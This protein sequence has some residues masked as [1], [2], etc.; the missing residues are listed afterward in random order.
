[1]NK[2]KYRGAKYGFSGKIQVSESKNPR[3]LYI[4]QKEAIKVLTQ[5]SKKDIFK[6]LLVIPTGGGKTF[7]SVYWVLKEIINKNKKVL[8]LAHRH[9]L[10]NQTLETAVKSSYKDVLPNR[11][12]FS[13]RIISGSLAHDNPV[14]IDKDD[15]FIIAS[16]DSLNYNP[17][18]LKT[19]LDNNKDNICLVIDEAHHATAKTYRN[20]IKMVENSCNNNLNIIGLT[21]TPMRTSEKEKGLLGKIFQDG[22]CYSVD[23]KT[24]I[25]NK[26]LS[27]PVIRDLKT[28]FKMKRELNRSELN[29]LTKFKNLPDSVAKDIAIN[30]ERNNFI[31]NNYIEN[32]AEYGK[33]LVFAVNID[34]A[35]ALNAL[36]KSKG[37]KSDFVVSSIKDGSTGAT[38]S[39]EE[40]E[41][42]IE[43]FRNN[44]LDVLINVNI[45]TEG[46]DIPDVQTV[47][48]TRPTTS[49][50]LMN[51]MI[52]RGLRGKKAGG[53]EK[54]YIVSFIDD[55]QYRI[56]WINPKN[57]LSFG[58]FVEDEIN[59][60]R[61][62]SATL[63]PIKMIEEFAKLMDLSI[64]KKMIGGSYL[65]L[66]PIGSYYFNIFDEDEYIDKNCEVLIFDHLIN[67]YEQLIENLE[68]IFRMFEVKDDKVTEE[69][70]TQMYEYVLNEIFAGYDL[71]IGFN[72]EDIKDILRYYE[73]TGE[74]LELIAFEGRED[75]DISKLVDEILDKRFNRIEEAEYIK[76]KWEDKSLGWQIYFN[77]DFLLFNSEID[78]EM[79]NRFIKIPKKE[80][81][82]DSNPIDFKTLSMHQIRKLDVNLWRKL[83][84]EVFN[85]FRD[86][87][88]Y[89]ES[90]SG[91]YK[92]RNK[93]YFQIDHIKPISKG[94]LTE[95][96]NLQLLTRWENGIKGDKLD[97]RF[98]ELESEYKEEALVECY[99]NKDEKKAQ[100]IIKMLL[101]ENEECIT[102]LNVRSRIQFENEKYM[103]AI[104]TANQVLNICEDNIYALYTKAN[105][106]FRQAKYEKAIDISEKII[107][108]NQE[109]SYAYIILGDCFY[110]LRKYN[111]AISYYHKALDIDSNI[112]WSNFRLGWIYSRNRRYNLSNQYYL[113]A[114]Q[115]DN[116]CADSLNNIGCNFL[117]VNDYEEALKYFEMALDI[118]S[119]EPVYKENRK[120]ALRE[121]KN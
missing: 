51:Q 39:N 14:N 50:I 44:K 6:S 3:G 72:E 30:K 94:G 12:E 77:R 90:A 36:F 80:P 97:F 60:K 33:C 95:P 18:Y 2:D 22:I 47:F 68:Y 31:V 84:D 58:E 20:I 89:Y 32:K 69:I 92:N 98:D 29:A 48:L 17:E 105:S 5:E 64:E 74:N 88:G 16:K 65:D 71:E 40:N 113:K 52:G 56:N 121:L 37:V 81:K 87:D 116:K 73:L 103:G 85:K 114:S 100:E 104:K 7:T 67:P 49:S 41:K 96:N 10:L 117:K 75:F 13:Y 55:W 108:I 46:T 110:E 78:R 109:E 53:T 1:M 34:H 57:L 106:Y 112:Y 23:L 15:D 66:V 91:S 102:A 26:I 120:S 76:N 59:K 86:E 9:E 8:W 119:N 38:I 82:V 118:E 107:N 42:K 27:K 4:H 99:Y 70:L 93:R 83:R 61:E 21:A 111:I 28:D 25:N 11:D 43:Y 62:L 63:V 54:A 45:L 19:W 24:L 35:I 79:R 101:E 115:L